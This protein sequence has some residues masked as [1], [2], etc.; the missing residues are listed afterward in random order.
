MLHRPDLSDLRSVNGQVFILRCGAAAILHQRIQKKTFSLLG[1]NPIVHVLRQIST[2]SMV[3]AAIVEAVRLG[4][5]R[6]L[7]LENSTDSVPM[8]V[9]WLVPQ[10]FII[11]AAEIMVNIGTLEMFYS[12]VRHPL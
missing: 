11:G 4:Q 1:L 5:V 6:R 12:E 9:I 2:F 8:S 7:G 3:A 10:Y